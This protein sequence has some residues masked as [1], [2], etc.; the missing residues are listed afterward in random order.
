MGGNIIPMLVESGAAQVYDFT[1][2][3]IPDATDRDRAYRR[4]GETGYLVQ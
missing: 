2:N 3:E 4:D 1:A